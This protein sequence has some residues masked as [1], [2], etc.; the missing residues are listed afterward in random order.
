M[1]GS[2]EVIERFSR[3][4]NAT[5]HL[6]RW[7]TD[8]GKHRVVPKVINHVTKIVDNL[9]P[10][11]VLKLCR[12]IAADSSKHA[13]G[14]INKKDVEKVPE[15]RDWHPDFAFTQLLHLVT[16][17]AGALLPF[18]DFI[19]HQVFKDAL[20][21][22]IRDKVSHVAQGDIPKQNLAKSAVRWRIGLAYYSFLKEQF[23]ISLMRDEG[24]NVK[25][26]PLAD[27]LFRVDCWVGDTNIDLYVTNPLY[28]AGGGNAG[29]KI[30]SAD[31]L[32]DAAPPF[33]NIILECKPRHRFGDVH[34]PDENDVR[35]ACK[36]LLP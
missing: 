32:R 33:N 28:R 10:S 36:I 17:E 6:N 29:R 26:H 20:Y 8:A 35:R 14:E 13:L 3:S 25:Q 34:L 16:E 5:A 22:Q 15:I 2:Q 7:R 27:A 1:T 31:L 21:D 19:R 24:V 12:E 30:R 18:D 11:D 9:Q 4:R 23:V